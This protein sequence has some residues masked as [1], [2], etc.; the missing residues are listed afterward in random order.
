MSDGEQK[1]AGKKVTLSGLAVTVAFILLIQLVAVWVTTLDAPVYRPYQQL[2]LV[3]ELAIRDG[4]HI[5]AA[6][7]PDGYT[8]LAVEVAP[9]PGLEPHAGPAPSP[10]PRRR[11]P[12]RCRQS[13]QSKTRI[14]STV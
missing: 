4:W 10:G 1:A 12:A 6:P 8:S 14:L 13:R 7:V 5:Y 9:S 11:R 3:I 2:Q